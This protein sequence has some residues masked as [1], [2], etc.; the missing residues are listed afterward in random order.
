[1]AQEFPRAEVV[2]SLSMLSSS[3]SEKKGLDLAPVQKEDVPDNCRFE[4]DDAS[5]GLP[6][7]DGTF[8]VVHARLL[9][10][11]VSV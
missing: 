8:D 11:G 3:R 6:F 4:I 9:T 10:V 7:P 2:V 1:M 5:R